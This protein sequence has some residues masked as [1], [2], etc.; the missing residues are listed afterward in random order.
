MALIFKGLRS[1]MNSG[2][3]LV[4]NNK[5]KATIPRTGRGLLMRNHLSTSLPETQ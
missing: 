2:P 5:Y 4:T 3:Y 1:F